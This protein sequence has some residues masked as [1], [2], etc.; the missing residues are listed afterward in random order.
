MVGSGWFCVVGNTE[1]CGYNQMVV[2]AFLVYSGKWDSTFPH[3][4]MYADFQ[5][6][7][8]ITFRIMKDNTC[9]ERCI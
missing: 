4:S 3:W 6:A 7:I 8:C 9:R 1:I 2:Y 5:E